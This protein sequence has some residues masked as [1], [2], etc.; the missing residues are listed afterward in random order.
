MIT[1]IDFDENVVRRIVRAVA[2]AVT[3][4]I[5]KYL[6]E[7]SKETNNAIGH[8]RGDYINENLK[9]FALS[10]G[11]ELLKFKRMSWQGRMLVDT[12]NKV[13]YSIT[14]QNTLS[15]IPKKKG[16]KKPHFLH[17]V[18]AIENKGYKP[19]SE[20]LTLFNMDEFTDEILERDYSEIVSGLI[21]PNEG[22]KHYVISYQAQHDEIIDIK[23]EFLDKNFNIIEQVSLNEYLDLD[24][25]KLTNVET[26]VETRPTPSSSEK[27]RGL[28]SVKPGLRPT[29]TELEKQG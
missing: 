25:S 9:A 29:L 10:E 26:F 5:P 23:L 22:Y 11:I 14:T 18:L 21:N 8:L 15:G 24:F 19:Q 20:Q 12:K 28:V 27:V 7:H 3:D 13:S 1:K 6:Y 16:R 2:K 17:S 4:D